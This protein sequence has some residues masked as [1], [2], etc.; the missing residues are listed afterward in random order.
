MNDYNGHC[1]IF[2]GQLIEDDEFL[3]CSD[4]YKIRRKI[5][6]IAWIKYDEGTMTA[7]SLVIILLRCNLKKDLND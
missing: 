1:P 4:H 6:E 5:F 2:S 7:S 3:T